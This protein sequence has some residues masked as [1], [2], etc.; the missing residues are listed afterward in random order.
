[1]GFYLAS[2]IRITIIASSKFIGRS[3][4]TDATFVYRLRQHWHYT[5]TV[6]IDIKNDWRENS[7]I[8]FKGFEISTSKLLKW[9]RSVRLQTFYFN[10][11]LYLYPFLV[12]NL[13]VVRHCNIAVD[14][15]FN[16]FFSFSLSSFAQT[17]E[18]ILCK[19]QMWQRFQRGMWA[20][21]HAGIRD[22]RQQ[23]AHLPRR[24]GMVGKRNWMH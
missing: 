10:T 6:K 24:R 22:A 19:R 13:V 20:K 8:K 16:L 1:M 7:R 9:Q 15:L 18:R 2:D 5:Y 4:F 14:K 17:K 21:L 3:R 12:V 23:F 11:L